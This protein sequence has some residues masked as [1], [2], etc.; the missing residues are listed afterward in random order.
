MA[1]L[2]NGNDFYVNI[3]NIKVDH[4]IGYAGTFTTDDGAEL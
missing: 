2:D 1:D 3:L 4:R